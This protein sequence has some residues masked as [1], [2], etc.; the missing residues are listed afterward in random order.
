MSLLEASSARWPIKP[1]F[2]IS[3]A[4]SDSPPEEVG[5]AVATLGQPHSQEG[6][7]V[8][9]ASEATG[10]PADKL[11]EIVQQIGGKGSLG[12]FASLLEGEGGFTGAPQNFFS[13]SGLRRAPG[14]GGSAREIAEVLLSPSWN[15]ATGTRGR[16]ASSSCAFADPF[17][18]GAASRPIH[19]SMQEAV[20][21]MFSHCG[22]GQA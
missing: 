18:P 3:L 16:Q 13:C 1:R 22:G 9:T 17:E 14:R 6:D 15:P 2:K 19:F 10:L 20:C 12:R 11:N 7:T 5:Q 4:R 8:Q 21:G